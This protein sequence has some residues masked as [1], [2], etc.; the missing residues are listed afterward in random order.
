MFDI[1]IVI[2]ASYDTTAYTFTFQMI[3]LARSAAY[4]AG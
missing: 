4:V 2:L 1:L 3:E